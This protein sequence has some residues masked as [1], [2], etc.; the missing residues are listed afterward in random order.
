MLQNREKNFVSCVL[1]LHNEGETVKNFL[2]EI[3]RVMQENFEKYEIICVNDG[4][5]DDTVEQVKAYLTE[6]AHKPVV[7]LVNL[8]YYQGVESAMNAGSDLAVGDF[9]FEFEKCQPEFDADLIM[10]VY[11]RALEGYDVVAAAP[12]HG[13]SFSSKL[14]Y[15]V[16]VLR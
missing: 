7:S 12:K 15:A 4:C 11:R 1:Y 6:T 3:C 5:V 9:L 13:V 14:F 8:S 2:S 10:Q 16:Y